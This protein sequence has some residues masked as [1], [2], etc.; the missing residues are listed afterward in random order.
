MTF[1]HSLC[2]SSKGNSTYIGNPD[3]GILVD[4]GIGI[5][6][7]T[8][9][10]QINNTGIN[11]IKAIFITHEHSDHTKG[12]IAISKRLDVPIYGSRETLE[13]LIAKDLVT[14]S[15]DLNEINKRSVSIGSME[16][17]AFS[18]PH[19]SA[20]SLGFSITDQSGKRICICT[21]LGKMTDEVYDSVKGCDFILIESNYDETMLTF[22]DYPYFLKHRIASDS[23]HLSN[24][25]CSKTLP[26]LLKDGTTKF[27]LGHL[28]ENNNRP[29]IALQASLSELFNTGAK[30][31]GDYILSVAPVRSVGEIIEV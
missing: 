19:D 28:S 4:A 3:C 1:V 9:N 25:M 26:R 21:D 24:E 23:G 18:T 2:S 22:G 30:L 7:F 5:R 29:E 11:A 12:L 13:Q 15:A 16:I 8:S 17:T 10:M 20:N 27:L 14:A 31:N 6:N